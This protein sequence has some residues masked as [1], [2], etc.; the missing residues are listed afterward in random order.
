[1]IAAPWRASVH[2]VAYSFSLPGLSARFAELKQNIH[3]ELGFF[4]TCGLEP[5][6]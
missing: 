1:M 3:D 2:I 4:V 5:D 6:R